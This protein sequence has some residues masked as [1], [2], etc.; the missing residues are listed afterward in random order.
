MKLLKDTI[1]AFFKRTFTSTFFYTF[2]PFFCMFICSV[3]IMLLNHQFQIKKIEDN[4]ARQLE[5]L[6]TNY[7]EKIT[8]ILNGS[9][10][11]YTSSNESNA[12]YNIQKFCDSN[13]AVANAFILNQTDN[14]VISSDGV[15]DINTYFTSV[16]QFYNYTIDYWKNFKFLDYSEYRILSPSMISHHD[17][18]TS[19][20]TLIIR[21]FGDTK[22]SSPIVI[23]IYT[24]H[25]FAIDD[26]KLLQKTDQ[27]YI[28][29]SIN[30]KLYDINGDQADTLSFSSPLYM[31]LISN[32]PLFE[33]KMD[34]K[35]YLVVSKASSRSLTGFVYF[36]LTPKSE[37]YKSQA[38]FTLSTI[39]TLLCFLFISL[40]LSLKNTKK[41]N[42][43]LQEL[44]GVLNVSKNSYDLFSELNSAANTLTFQK[45]QLSSVLTHAHEKFLINMLNDTEYTINEEESNFLK[46]SLKFRYD[47]FKV[48]IIQIYPNEAFFADYNMDE[49]N[50]IRSGLYN[51][52][53]IL[54]SEK[55]ISYCLPVEKEVLHII[56]NLSS[57][58][59]QEDIDSIMSMFKNSLINDALQVNICIGQSELYKGFECIKTAHHEAMDNMQLF[60]DHPQNHFPQQC[61]TV[62]RGF[63][64]DK[65]FLYLNSYNMGEASNLFINYTNKHKHDANFNDTLYSVLYAIIKTMQTKKIS[66]KYDITFQ[67][68]PNYLQQPFNKIYELVLDLIKEIGASKIYHTQKST[69]STLIDYISENYNNKNISLSFLAN[70]FG[71]TGP[72]VSTIVKT[73]TGMNFHEYITHLRI[74]RAKELLRKNE[75]SVQDIA[76]AVG[77][78]SRNTF[79]RSF[80]QL[81]GMTP[82]EYKQV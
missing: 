53:K 66:S 33:H 54:F 45:H 47:Y 49:Y 42:S 13:P 15:H 9:K 24:S 35:N 56:L 17:T 77:F 2:T 41:I 79:L 14:T 16:C 55:Y 70:K 7:D 48:I 37:I 68:I 59:A 62:R 32:R 11:L 3:A 67:T 30:A 31:N 40:T 76:S 81:T 74:E 22:V 82:S 61:D 23:N 4:M 39:L 26:S 44:A 6:Q 65:F 52:I 64:T 19:V 60:T 58:E 73:G 25:F 1:T 28:L 50:S 20:L 36:I 18:E 57:E 38:P 21:Q 69:T 63:D 29:S 51:S 78:S 10:Y 75:L 80:K 8:G 34:N 72:Y 12:V 46:E 5:L 71:I 27:F 43:P